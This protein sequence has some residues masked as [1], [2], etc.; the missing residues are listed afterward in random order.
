MD[1]SI[2]DVHSHGVLENIPRRALLVIIMD[3]L[4][5]I[6][7]VRPA[8]IFNGRISEAGRYSTIHCLLTLP[9]LEHQNMLVQVVFGRH[10]QGERWAVCRSAQQCGVNKIWHR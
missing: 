1:V 2:T 6:L 7:E 10:T 8:H 9:V 4:G 5:H 3:D